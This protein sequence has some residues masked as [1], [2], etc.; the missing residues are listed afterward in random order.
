MDGWIDGS[1]GSVGGRMVKD[2]AIGTYKIVTIN[3]F[4]SSCQATEI[5]CGRFVSTSFSLVVV[6]V[7]FRFP[8]LKSQHIALAGL[9]L[10]AHA[11]TLGIRML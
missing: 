5:Y 7:V 9:T 6:F 10:Q 8:K 3:L 2:T 11:I 1:D 4:I